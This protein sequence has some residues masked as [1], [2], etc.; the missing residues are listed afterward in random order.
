M[1]KGGGGRLK[2]TK[3]R[4]MECGDLLSPSASVQPCLREIGRNVCQPQAH[5]S[6]AKASMEKGDCGMHNN[7]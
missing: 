1:K 2:D 7:V 6:W 4:R 5:R 3:R